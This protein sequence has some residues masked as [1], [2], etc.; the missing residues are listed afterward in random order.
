MNTHPQY[1]EIGEAGE[2]DVVDQGCLFENRPPSPVNVAQDIV[3][4]GFQKSGPV[5]ASRVR[6]V[7]PTVNCLPCSPLAV[8]P[9]LNLPAGGS[10]GQGPRPLRLWAEGAGRAANLACV[11]AAIGITLPQPVCKNFFGLR[12]TSVGSVR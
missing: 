4:Q 1:D 9:R 7:A 5:P 2:V 3:E 12:R 11:A 6:R 8:N 10:D